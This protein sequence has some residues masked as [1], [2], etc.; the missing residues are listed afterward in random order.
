MKP[1]ILQTWA[2]PKTNYRVALLTDEQADKVK[3]AKSQFSFETFLTLKRYFGK[4]PVFWSK[5]NATLAALIYE[6]GEPESLNFTDYIF[7]TEK[8]P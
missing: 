7:P 3:K 6:K 2:R 8:K 4:S 5:E 1:Y